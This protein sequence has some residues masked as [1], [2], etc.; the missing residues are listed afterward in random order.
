[1]KIWNNSV[2]LFLRGRLGDNLIFRLF[3]PLLHSLLGTSYA[4][5]IK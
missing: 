4:G 5:D 1:M 2:G 3:F